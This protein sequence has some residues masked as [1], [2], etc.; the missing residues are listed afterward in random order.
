M[1]RANKL[2]ILTA[3]AAMLS[4]FEQGMHKISDPY[5]DLPPLTIQDGFSRRRKGM[6][7]KVPL[8]KG[9]MKARNKAKAAKQARKVNRKKK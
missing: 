7:S 6:N 9:Q 3:G 4:G 8:T 5:S 2:L 1:G